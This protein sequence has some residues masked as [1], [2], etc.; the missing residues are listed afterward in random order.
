MR[1]E[2]SPSLM[3]ADLSRLEEVVV[4]L[5]RAGAD[6]FHFDVMDGHFV[7]NFGLSPDLIRALRPLTRKPFTVHLMVEEPEPF[8][9]EFAAAGATTITVCY[10]ACRNPHPLLEA[11]RR[12]GVRSG[13][14][15][16]PAT[17]PLV[18]EYLLPVVDEVL[19][20]TVDPG[21]AGQPFLSPVLPKVGEVA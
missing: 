20:M 3:C 8:L 18:L 13:L 1:I 16:S 12:L 9:A 15:L 19:V 2:I 4:R 11:V 6:S 14:A 7:P 17:P 10:E 5:D 21:F